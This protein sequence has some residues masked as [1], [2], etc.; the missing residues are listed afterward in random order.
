MKGARLIRAAVKRDDEL[1]ENPT[2]WS[3]ENC[4]GIAERDREPVVRANDQTRG[5]RLTVRCAGGLRR[6]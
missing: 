4:P 3:A 5:T 2:L 6:R 1:K